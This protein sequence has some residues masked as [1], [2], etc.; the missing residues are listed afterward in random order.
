MDSFDTSSW[1]HAELSAWEAVT[2]PRYRVRIPKGT[3]VFQQ[4]ETIRHLYIVEEGYLVQSVISRGGTEKVLMDMTRGSI[5]GELCLFDQQVQPYG[6]RGVTDCTVYQIPK[7]RFLEKLGDDGALS[8]LVMRLLTWKLRLLGAQIADLSFGTIY[9]R[10]AWE[11]LSLAERYGVP[12][13]GGIRLE[14]PLTQQGVADKVKATRESVNAVMRR[15]TAEGML[16]KRDGRYLIRDPEAMRE[17][18]GFLRD[19]GNRK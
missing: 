3:L 17:A 1:I 11:L 18:F 12:C 14:T 4:G 13:A 15:M 16:E 7:E 5:F 10:V 9:Q 19:G 2:A 6:V 8:F